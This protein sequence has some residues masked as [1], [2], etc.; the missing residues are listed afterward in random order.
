MTAGNLG[1]HGLRVAV[2]C[3][4]TAAT[5]AF[6]LTGRVV[7]PSG[8]PM[9]RAHVSVA[10][11]PNTVTTD[12]SGQFVIEPDPRP[13]FTIIVIGPRGEI[14]QP[15]EVDTL[16]ETPLEIQLNATASEAITVTTGVTP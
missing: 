9:A 4:L 14:Y 2:F 7:A 13:P 1:R 10:G 3:L 11:R 15:I 16:A 8:Q 12:A 6:A 5:E